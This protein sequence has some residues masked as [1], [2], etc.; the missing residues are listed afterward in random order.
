VDQIRTHADYS[1]RTRQVTAEFDERAPATAGDLHVIVTSGG[2]TAGPDHDPSGGVIDKVYGVDVSIAIRSPRKPRDRQRELWLD[3]T[4]SFET[5]SRSIE[6]K[7]D[8]QIAVMTAANVYIAA[9]ESS[10]DGFQIPL[11]LATVGP[12]REA[13]PEIFAG[14]GEGQAALIRKLEFRGARR[15]KNR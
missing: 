6:S 1:S 14:F 9:E 4:K 3:L 2:I 10:T 15:K 11:R 8:Y 7:V 12:I 5:F 13:P